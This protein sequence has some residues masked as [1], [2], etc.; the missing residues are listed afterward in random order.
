MY[1]KVKNWFMG[2]LV[3]KY[4]LGYLV[5]AWDFADGYKTQFSSAAAVVVLASGFLG[6]VDIGWAM[7]IAGILGGAGFVSFMDKLRKHKGLILKAQTLI[8]QERAK[9]A[10]QE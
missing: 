10:A 6:Y 5:Q 7:D 2:I 3:H 8:D 9:K 4:A 1:K